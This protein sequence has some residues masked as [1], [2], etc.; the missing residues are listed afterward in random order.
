MKRRK[1]EEG[2]SEP[3]EEIS[4][5][6]EESGGGRSDSTSSRDSHPSQSNAAM[7]RMAEQ[8]RKHL[9]KCHEETD[10]LFRGLEEFEEKVKY[11]T[12]VDWVEACKS[13]RRLTGKTL[14]T[15]EEVVMTEKS[16]ERCK[17]GVRALRSCSP[18]SSRGLNGP[19]RSTLIG[20]GGPRR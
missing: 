5:S 1:V 16:C 9:K 11:V 4:E 10:A 14:E 15:M 18:P 19:S 13:L 12:P 20:T 3:M 7:K 17:G 2:T 8:M 6:M